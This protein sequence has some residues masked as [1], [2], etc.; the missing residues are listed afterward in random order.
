[1]FKNIKIIDDKQALLILETGDIYYGKSIGKKGFSIGELCFNTA[2]TGYQEAISDP[3]YASQILMFTFPHIGITGTNK[4]DLESEKIHLNGVVFKNVTKDCSNWRSTSTLD[5][6]LISKKIVGITNLNT[7][8]LTVKLRENGALRAAI[9]SYSKKNISYLEIIKKL[10]NWNGIL[11]NDLASKV[12]VKKP[13]SYNKTK[14][15]S[16]K[17]TLKIVAVDYGC[18]KNILELLNKVGFEVI[19]VPCNYS[20]DKI[21]QYNPVGIFLSNGP[22]DPFATAKNAVKTIKKLI[23]IKIPIFGICLG[24]QLLGLALDAKTVKMHHGHH[25]VN[26]PVKKINDSSIEIT[27]QNHGFNIEE[28]SLPSN[29]KVSHYSLFDGV[30]QGIEHKRDPFFSV[31][32][33][34]ESSPGPHDS[35]YLFEKFKKTILKSSFYAKKKRY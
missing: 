2:M 17:N 11:N 19:V 10:K 16:S 14:Q 33:H 9:L 8:K 12:S 21:M 25:G 27:S 15:K 31:Q 24:H 32:F 18:K 34:P 1:M 7:R 28:K 5:Q 4:D 29:L 20:F 22:G 13:Y 23:K 3:S 6:W 30:I 26:Q 35:R